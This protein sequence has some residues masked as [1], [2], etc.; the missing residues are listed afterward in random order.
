M[1]ELL[2]IDVILAVLLVTSFTSVG[3]LALWTAT[4]SRH[5]FV[6]TAI[7]IACLSPLL[8]VPALEVFVAFVIEC[9]IISAGVVAYRRSRP[10]RRISLAGSLLITAL[11]AVAVSIAALLPALNVYAWT[12]V[13]LNGAA[14]GTAALL[15]AWFFVSRRKWIAALAAIIGCVVVGTALSQFDWFYPSIVNWTGWPPEPSTVRVFPSFG[16]AKRPIVAWFVIPVI[17][18]IAVAFCCSYWHAMIRQ[19]KSN[20][21]TGNPG[22]R[23]RRL[24]RPIGFALII[25]LFAAMP[26]Y[27]LYAL[28]NPD[29]IPK[30]KLPNPNGYED[31]LAAGNLASSTGFNGLNFDYGTATRQALSIEV[32]KCALVYDHVASGLSRQTHVPVNY[33]FSAGSLPVTDI[34]NFRSVARA[35]AGK[36]RLA[37]LEGRFSDAAQCSLEGIAFGQAISRGGLLIDALVGNACAGINMYRLYHERDRIPAEELARCVDRLQKLDANIEP[38]DEVWYRDRVWSQRTNGWHGHLQQLLGDIIKQ[39]WDFIFIRSDQIPA[40]Y[41]AHQAKLRLAM[42][43]FALTRFHHELGRWPASINEL[44]P[45]YILAIPVDPFDPNGRPLKYRKTASGYVVYSVGPN[46]IDD[47]GAPPKEDDFSGAPETGD[48]RLDVAF[49]P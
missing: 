20:V 11:A 40:T 48:V 44:T 8:I 15:G 3:L 31:W 33:S 19:F 38:F 12:T 4:S 18:A 13:A 46:Q 45:K 25:A 37:E 14:G 32:G 35:I 36:A 29:P 41:K 42:L 28:L 24:I 34:Q 27:V 6:R 7:V 10:G 16:V 43:E 23:K 49:K 5:W 26:L 30:T 47:G 22:W 2:N 21:S 1:H 9:A 39:T 17:V